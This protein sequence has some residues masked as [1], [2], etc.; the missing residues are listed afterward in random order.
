MIG[1]AYGVLMSS[2][3]EE[4]WIKYAFNVIENNFT[5]FKKY[6]KTPRQMILTEKNKAKQ[7]I[8]TLCLPASAK[9]LSGLLEWECKT[10]AVEAL[11]VL[12]HYQI[13]VPSKYHCEIIFTS[14]LLRMY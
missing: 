8:L 14:C 11:T 6:L 10:D 9:T 13:R 2:F 4:Y 1:C 5:L 12:N 3:L 7:N